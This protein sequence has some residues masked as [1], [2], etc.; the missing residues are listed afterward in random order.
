MV[1]YIWKIGGISMYNILV[2]DDE[3][4]IVEAIKIYL[5]DEGYNVFPCYDGQ[6]A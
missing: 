1:I 4:E 3:K 2:V 6:E 5:E